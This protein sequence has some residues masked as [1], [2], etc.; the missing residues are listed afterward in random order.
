MEELNTIALGIAKKNNYNNEEIVKNISR[1]HYQ[2]V[3]EEKTSKSSSQC[4]TVRDISTTIKAISEGQE[5]CDAVTCFYGSRYKGEEFKYLNEI[6]QCKYECLYKD[7]N[8]IPELPKDFP[9]C[10]SNLSLRKAFYFANIAKRNNRHI[11]IVGKEGSG[12]TQVAKWIYI[13]LFYSYRKKKRKFFIF[14]FSRN[15]C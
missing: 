10:F 4:F 7:I 15:N 14:L 6:L 2:W 9:K 11:L 12:I 5:P 8:L 3:Y 1:F 13:S